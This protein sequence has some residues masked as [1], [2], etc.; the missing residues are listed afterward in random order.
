[1]GL[2]KLQGKE[3]GDEKIVN[4]VPRVK[5]EIKGQEISGGKGNQKLM[6]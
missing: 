4:N 6:Q 3:K 1:M 5:W 2:R